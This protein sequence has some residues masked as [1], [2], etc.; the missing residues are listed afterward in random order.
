MKLTMMCAA[1]AVLGFA[2]GDDKTG[3]TDTKIPLFDTD[4]DTDTA[5]TRD[6]AEPDTTQVDTGDTADGSD[7]ADADDAADAEIVEGGVGAPCQNNQECLSGFCVEG[8]MGFVCTRQCE[9][10]CPFGWDCKGVSGE[11]DVVFL[12]LPR[13][14]KLCAPCLDDLQC[15]GGV[16]TS[17]DGEQRCAR[18]CGD[19]DD[20]PSGFSC[21]IADGAE[22]GNCVPETG[23]CTCFGEYDGGIRSCRN[24]N[25]FGTCLGL[26]ACDPAVGWGGCDARTPAAETCNGQDDDCDAFFDEDVSAVG[27]VCQNAI[28]GVGSCTGVTVCAG[29]AGLQCQGPTPAVETC[30]FEDDDC[31]GQ[32]D[33]DMKTGDIY[34]AFDHCGTCNRSCAVGFPNAA[35]TTCQVS[36]GIA[37]CV[38]VSCEAGYIKQNDFQC[39]PDIVNLCEACSSD[40][41]CLG[42]GSACVTLSDG[43]FCAKSCTTNAN[44]PTGFA[45]QTVAGVAAKQC[46]PTT[47]VC[48]CG[49]STQGLARGCSVTVSPAGQPSTT[50]VGTETCGAAGWG[51]CALPGETCNGFD[52]D[53]DGSIDGPF[54]NAAGKYNKVEHCGGCGISCL[55]LNFQNADPICDA[56]GAGAPQCSFQCKGSYV[57][58][59]GLPG[60]ECLPSSAT[61]LPD[62]NGVDANCDGIDGELDKAIFVAKTGRDNGLGTIVDPLRTIQAGINKAVT[63]GK[64]DVLVATG[65]YSE[66]I[67]LANKVNVYGGYSPDF[68]QRDRFTHES[69]ILGVDPTDALRGTVNATSIAT[70]AAN[71]LIFD[72]FSVFGA[73]NATAGGSS[74]AIYLREAGQYLTVSNNLV[75]AGNGGNGAAGTKGGDGTRGT[76]GTQGIGSLQLAANA[77]CTA[78]SHATGGAGG[79]QSCGGTSTQGGA[80]GT[81]VC[82]KVDTS[83]TT[84]IQVPTAAENGSTGANNAASAGSGGEAG[85]HDRIQAAGCGT[86]SSSQN[87]DSYGG[88]GKNGA[89]GTNG[90]PGAMCVGA[91][92]TVSNGLW[93]GAAAGDGTVGSH[94]GGGG[95]GGAAGGVDHTRVSPDCNAVPFV[96]GGSGGGGG[97]GGCRGGV[98]SSGSSGGGSFGIFVAY[99]A[100]PTALPKIRDNQVV[101]GRGGQGGPGGAG[102]VGGSG[103]FGGLGGAANR[104]NAGS[105]TFPQVCCGSGG[106]AGGYGGAGGHGPGGAGGC[107][108]PSMGIFVAPVAAGLAATYVTN[109]TVTAG[110]GAAGTGGPGG[111]SLGNVGPSGGAGLLRTTSY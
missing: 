1:L 40:A 15:N 111:T 4:Q 17:I 101:R 68:D 81:R 69:A 51:A 92:G 110:S 19:G 48:S 14:D 35:Q 58:V 5:D 86:V 41:N 103:G 18:K 26:E 50:C 73:S 21:D 42:Q 7:A 72:G 23:S 108:G 93:T 52:D 83:V 37:Q 62:V 78:A 66:S 24:Q 82:P 3:E 91:V 31:D 55:A 56:S 61:D 74:Y 45:C 87:H 85:W 106:G 84:T 30:D 32:V 105:G 2:C 95:G 63:L 80:G 88:V 79:I 90:S 34:T 25:T 99:A 9:T 94:G 38:V 20:C 53:C 33:E 67:T 57:D 6:T 76:D 97:S 44:C 29:A 47:G 13:L 75:V 8:P 109:N 39:I 60:C 65:V 98:G 77:A 22:S 46:L 28:P 16:C 10:Q 104:G 12:C 43:R 27:G 102:G 71:A 36:Q 54:K 107:G 49:P 59:D 11:T 100:L 96:L 70:T 89:E 64:R